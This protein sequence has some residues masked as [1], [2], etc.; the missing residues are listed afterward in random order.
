VIGPHPFT[1]LD[2]GENYLY[3]SAYCASSCSLHDVRR[4]GRATGV[5]PHREL[6]HPVFQMTAQ[7]PSGETQELG[8]GWAVDRAWTGD[9]TAGVYRLVVDG[10]TGVRPLHLSLAVRVPAGMHVVSAPGMVVT[11]GGVTWDGEMGDRKVFEV[12]F[13][14]SLVGRIWHGVLDFLTQPVLT[15]G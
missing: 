7:V 15:V 3:M 9:S 6:G 13:Q 2:P 4:D 12:R 5:A 1:R 8:F 10:Q 14:R 11:D